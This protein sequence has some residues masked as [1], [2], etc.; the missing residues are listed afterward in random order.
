[1]IDMIA[2]P[3]KLQI[4]HMIGAL[5]DVMKRPSWI[6]HL[7]DCV[8]AGTIAAII[9]WART[10]FS[11][12]QVSPYYYRRTRSEPGALVSPSCGCSGFFSRRTNWGSVNWPPRSLSRF[13]GGVW[14]VTGDDRGAG[15]VREIRW[16]FLDFTT[17]LQTHKLCLLD[18]KTADQKAKTTNEFVHFLMWVFPGN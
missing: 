9:V 8:T 2:A 6:L 18:M 7:S 14:G 1:M 3:F 12:C 16:R 10:H 4:L 11:F 15:P 5:L 17:K 13:T